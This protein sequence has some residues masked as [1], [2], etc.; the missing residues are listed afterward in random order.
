MK[1]VRKYRDEVRIKVITE[2]DEAP[3]F[4]NNNGTPMKPTRLTQMTK[5]Y[6]DS[7]GLGKSG[8]CHIF[9]HSMATL[10]L[11]HL[12]I[13][14]SCHAY[15]G[16]IIGDDPGLYQGIDYQDQGNSPKDPSWCITI[17]K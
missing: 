3:L 15:C 12:R 11:E 10:M 16:A 7:A 4:L 5:R 14:F 2:P 13:R 9:R 1:W 6:I 17:E 8:S